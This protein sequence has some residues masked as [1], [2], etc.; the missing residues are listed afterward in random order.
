MRARAVYRYVE[1]QQV[2]LCLEEWGLNIWAAPMPKLPSGNYGAVGDFCY[3]Q[4]R[5]NVEI[6]CKRDDEQV[7]YTVRHELLHVRLADMG[8]VFEQAVGRLGAETAEVL[9]AQ[10]RIAEERAVT[11]IAMALGDGE[12]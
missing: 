7:R 9:R 10:Y 2:R 6:A 8:V 4:P 12:G 1:K 3:N 11:A 5:V